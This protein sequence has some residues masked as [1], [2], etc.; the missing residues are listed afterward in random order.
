VRNY[1]AVINDAEIVYL[2]QA[3]TKDACN[4]VVCHY[5]VCLQGLHEF[6]SYLQR[7]WDEILEDLE[8]PDEIL[9]RLKSTHRS[10][11]SKYLRFLHLICLRVDP[12]D[13]V[14]VLVEL[15]AFK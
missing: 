11:H 12:L 4:L 1:T 3:T 2:T 13:P 8:V 14:N 9:S 7:D 10:Y 6:N 5:E 15:L